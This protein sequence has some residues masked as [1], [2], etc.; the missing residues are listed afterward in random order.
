MQVTDVRV[1]LNSGNRVKAIVD[2]VLDNE[3]EIT[4]IRIVEMSNNKFLI[5]FPNK[6]Y[7]NRFL[8]IAHPINSRTRE[9]IQK[10]ILKKYNKMLKK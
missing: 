2:L 5:A 7:K 10:E 4:G 3:L 9:Y 8:D 6:R 1:T